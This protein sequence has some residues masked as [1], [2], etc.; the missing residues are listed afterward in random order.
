MIQIFQDDGYFSP[1]DDGD[2]S[3]FLT[4]YH[5]DFSVDGPRLGRTKTDKGRLLVSKDDCIALA[6]GKPEAAARGLEY[7]EE[8]AVKYHFFGLEAYI[9][10]GVR[11]A[12]GREGNFPDRQWDVSQVGMIFVSKK[13]WRT[14]PRAKK[15]AACLIENWNNYLSGNV[16]G[17]KVLAE[18]DDLTD[19][20]IEVD[21]CWGFSGDY[22][23]KG[24]CLDD[25]RSIADHH[26][27]QA[28]ERVKAAG[29]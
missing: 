23:Q 26:N 16:Y 24:G 20:N 18:P 29:I 5:R 7:P 25:A 2:E 9:H 3:L 11:L 21:S 19:E 28:P 14:R 4:G 12:F 1:E 17:F 6:I 10:S 15:A 22:D 13:E 27:K 8:L